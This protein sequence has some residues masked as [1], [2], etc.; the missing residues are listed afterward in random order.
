MDDQLN[1]EIEHSLRNLIC[2]DR[3]EKFHFNL[4]QNSLFENS[5]EYID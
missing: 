4:K 3:D 2:L 1:F 5:N